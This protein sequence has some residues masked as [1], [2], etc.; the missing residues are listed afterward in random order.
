MKGAGGAVGAGALRSSTGT[1]KPQ[2]NREDVP[3]LARSNSLPKYITE[4]NEKTAQFHE[5]RKAEKKKKF[6]DVNKKWSEQRLE[7]WKVRIK[8]YHHL[9]KK[10]PSEDNYYFILFYSISSHFAPSQ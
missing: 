10:Q 1:W 5:E 4:K 2:F 9:E 7:E 3:I 6:E 8:L